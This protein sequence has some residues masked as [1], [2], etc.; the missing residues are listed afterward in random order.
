MRGNDIHGL[1][2]ALFEELKERGVRFDLFTDHSLEMVKEVVNEKQYIVWLNDY[3]NLKP[4]FIND[5][6]KAFYGF[7]QN[8]LS[9]KGFD[10]Y[11][12]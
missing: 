8:D 1:M 7:D 12:S 5:F 6:G 3:Q 2:D 9:N 10:F 4:V 11:R